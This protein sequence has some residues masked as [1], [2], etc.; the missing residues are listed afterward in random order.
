MIPRVTV[1]ENGK[2]HHGLDFDPDYTPPLPKGAIRGD[3]RQQEFCGMCHVPKYYFVDIPRV[4]VQ[5]RA[6][7]VFS[8]REQKHWYE[9][10]KF[11]F[12][13]IATRCLDCRRKRRSDQ[14]LRRQLAEAKAAARRHADDPGA[15]LVLVEAIVRYFERFE[16]GNLEEAVAAS[17]KARRLFR[18]HPSKEARRAVFWEGMSQAFAGRRAQARALLEKFL[19]AGSVGR[20]YTAL[21]VEAKRWLA[22]DAR[23]ESNV[24]GSPLSADRRDKSARSAGR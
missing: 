23:D 12:D 4:C 10:L 2:V 1:L 3:I 17:R 20:G 5:C 14:A 18:G 8:A 7:F 9:T 6:P 13:S 15:Q 21:Y 16:E 11:N 19:A 24:P 22:A